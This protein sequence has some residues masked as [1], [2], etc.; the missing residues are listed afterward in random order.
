[1]NEWLNLAS[2]PNVSSA[3][4]AG[5]YDRKDVR[6]KEESILP[7]FDLKIQNYG[8]LFLSWKTSRYISVNGF[9]KSLQKNQTT[10]NPK[11]GL[12]A[13]Q[14]CPAP[15]L[16][17]ALLLVVPD[18]VEGWG[19]TAMR[20]AQIFRILIHLPEVRMQSEHADDETSSSII[21]MFWLHLYFLKLYQTSK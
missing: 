14:L 13:L 12:L 18:E 6:L 11:F 15:Q 8:A 3:K 21:T 5:K 4:N 9:A 17:Q 2:F 19:I 10:E 7:I 20:V 1:M 16:H